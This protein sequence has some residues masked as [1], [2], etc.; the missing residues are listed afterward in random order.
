[1][2]EFRLQNQVCKLTITAMVMMCKSE[3]IYNNFSIHRIF[4]LSITCQK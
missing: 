4:H 1:M 3:V 2:P